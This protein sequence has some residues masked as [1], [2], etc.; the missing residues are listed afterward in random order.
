MTSALKSP[1]DQPSIGD[2]IDSIPI[3]DVD[4]HL[5]E[6]PDIWTSRLS[7]A[8][9]G[10]AI[11]HMVRSDTGV[12]T[13]L[14]G[15]KPA[16]RSGSIL[17]RDR[18]HV[19]EPIT[20]DSFPAHPIYEG[21]AWRGAFD[22]S[23]RLAWMDQHGIRSQVLYPNLVGFFIKPFV[24]NLEPQLA[25]ECM[26]A[27]NDH[28]ADFCSAAPDRLIAL[29][30]LPWWDLDAAIEEL[31]RCVEL[32]HKGVNFGW[33]FEQLGF[34]RLRDPHWDR[35]LSAIQ[36]TGLSVNFHIG[37][38]GDPDD[39]PALQFDTRLDTLDRVATAAA[40][41]AG[42][43]HCIT[44]LIMS[45]LC[46]RYPKLR[47]VSVESGVGFIPYLL[48]ALDW[49]FMNQN[50]HRK[51]PDWL[52]P[53]EYFRRQIYGCFWFE[54]SVARVADL[55]PDNFM[56]ETDFNHPASLTP[57]ERLP[58]VK[59]PRDLIIENL[60]GLPAVLVRKLLHDNAA[61]VYHLTD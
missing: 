58:S 53:S 43:L 21:D 49:Q 16:M 26:R 59:S 3:H 23:A 47:F 18:D 31:H 42:N 15:G 20:V 27:F 54:K 29:A 38:A 7:S 14:V 51:Y 4:T 45:G 44:E 33:R 41:F 60:D 19:D 24:V 56:F 17:P 25:T 35:L 22:P 40:L 34:P 39:D 30:N 12:L 6:V 52:L 28:Q 57:A 13:W 48:E 46:R 2:L 1:Q 9:W 10:D 37:F 32:G 55:Y 61:N 5:V 8:R 50:L 11:P 36:E